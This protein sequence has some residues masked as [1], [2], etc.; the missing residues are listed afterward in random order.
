MTTNNGPARLYRN[1]QTTGNRSIR[2]RLA[3]VKSNRDGIGAVVKATVA[4]ETSTRVVRSGSSY[5][6]QSEMPAT[7]GIARHDHAERLLVYWPS[8]QVDEFKNVK[9]GRWLCTED[10]ASARSPGG[11]K[12]I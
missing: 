1:D 6:S 5:L 9:P 4:S 2:V 8:G 3:G 11:K 7:F 12:R 10:K